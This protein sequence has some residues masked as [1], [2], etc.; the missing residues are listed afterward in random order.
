MLGIQGSCL[1][2]VIYGIENATMTSNVVSAFESA[3]IFRSVNRQDTWNCN[4]CMLLTEVMKDFSK[5]Q[6]LNIHL[7]SLESLFDLQ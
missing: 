1:L 7:G 4:D 2:R 6:K 3:G 5:I